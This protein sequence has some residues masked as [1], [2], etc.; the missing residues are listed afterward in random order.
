MAKCQLFSFILALKG[1]CFSNLIYILQYKS[2]VSLCVFLLICLHVTSNTQKTQTNPTLD[3]APS[4]N[5][6]H[7]KRPHYGLKQTSKCSTSK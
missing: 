6:L 2:Y 5:D 7:A 1:F 4:S 3:N